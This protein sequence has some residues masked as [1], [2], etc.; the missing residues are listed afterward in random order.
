[1]IPK[2][3]DPEHLIIIILA[4]LMAIALVGAGL[5]LGKLIG[6]LVNKLLGRENINL[7]VNTGEN[8]MAETKGVGPMKG[9]ICDPEKCAPLV[10]IRGQQQRN[11]GDIEKLGGDI[12][13]WTVL[14]FKKL[15]FIQAQNNVILRCLVKNNQLNESDI[16]KEAP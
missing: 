12:R 4:L 14:F 3:N 2:L 5:G 6:P 10:A 16:P 15:T 8:G 13:D 9:G 7:T 11:I 1:M